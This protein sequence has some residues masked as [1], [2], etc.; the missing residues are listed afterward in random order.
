[1]K[2]TFELLD[3]VV[4]AIELLETGR[5]VLASSLQDM[6]TDLSPLQKRYPEPALFLSTFEVS[7]MRQLRRLL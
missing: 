7:L 1:M 5:G 4:P 2:T 3:Q 6:C